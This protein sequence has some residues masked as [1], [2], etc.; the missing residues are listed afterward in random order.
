MS[1][2]PREA[3]SESSWLADFSSVTML[4]AAVEARERAEEASGGGRRKEL[5]AAVR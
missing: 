3:M 2:S 4:I 1:L 5:R